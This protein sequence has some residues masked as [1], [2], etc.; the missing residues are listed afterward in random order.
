MKTGNV[1]VNGTQIYYEL[2]GSGPSVLFISGATGDAGHFAKI[3]DILGREFAVVT[4]DR[5]GNSRSPR[6]GGWTATSMDEQAD[7]AGGL[8]NAL[9]LAPAAVFGTSGGGDILLSLIVRHPKL[10]RGA[11]VHEPALFSILP[12]PQETLGQWQSMVEGAMAKGGPRFA[13]EQFVRAAAGN[14][15][16][17]QLEPKLR[18]RMIGNAEVFF[19][20]EMKA[21][22]SYS[23]DT[24]KLV[25]S[26]VPVLVAAGA[27][28]AT[29][30]QLR[31][32]FEVSRL[33]AG[34]LGS[35]LHEFPG[36]HGG[37]MDRPEEFVEALL[38][39]LAK[40]SVVSAQ[41]S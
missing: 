21:F 37:Y 22:L 6:P 10:L 2:R 7:D 17:E 29:N 25:E 36:A 18:E 16:F 38:P 35:S 8:I 23:V 12:N 14:A 27:E 3:A 33:L 13:M 11:V 32:I 4:Y 26:N 5:R 9:D 41:I 31:S 20:I 30:P 19:S 34:R 28:T 40:L 24:R 39:L 15:V 1:V